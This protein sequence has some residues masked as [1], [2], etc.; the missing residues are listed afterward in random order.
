MNSE[1]TIAGVILTLN[2]AQDLHRA[3]RSLSWCNEVIVLDSGS[4]DQTKAIALQTGA[5]FYQRIPKPPFLITDQRNW[6][7]THCEIT[8]D[9]ILFLDADEE[10]SPRLSTVI[11]ETLLTSDQFDGYELAPRFWFMGRWLKHCQS[12]PCWHPRLV[13]RIPDPFVGGVWESFSPALR[14]GKIKFPYEHYAYSKGLDSWIIK[15]LRYADHESDI[16]LKQTATR[17][18]LPLIA[19]RAGRLRMLSAFL[20]PIRP[21]LRLFFN[22][23]LRLGFLDGWQGLIYSLMMSIYESFV[24]IKVLEK[25]T[26]NA[27]TTLN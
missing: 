16:V 5:R 7:L 1:P 4:T 24:V 12:F 27:P 8:S 15:H 10:V 2:E 3:L 6:A 9:W 17:G 23:F 22:Y 11:I 19:L 21:V 20:W 14:I 18:T 13:R 25:K 26:S